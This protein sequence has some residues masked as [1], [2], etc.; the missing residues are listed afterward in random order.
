MNVKEQQ[1]PIYMPVGLV[2]PGHQYSREQGQTLVAKH[3][4]QDTQQKHIRMQQLPSN[5]LENKK[6]QEHYL[7]MLS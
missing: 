5:I 6:T 2:V 4:W 3:Q 1:Q 7:H